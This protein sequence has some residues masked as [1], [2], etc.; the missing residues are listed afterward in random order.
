[1][2]SSRPSAARRCSCARSSAGRRACWSAHCAAD[3]MSP[4]TLYVFHI[5]Y[6][7]GKMQAYLRYKDIPHDTIEPKWGGEL[8][9]LIYPNTGLM[10]VPVVRTPEGQWLADSTPMIDWFEQRHPQGAVIPSDPLQ[11]FFSRLLEDY[12]DEWLWRPALHYRWSYPADAHALSRRF[13][14][15]FLSEQPMPKAMTAAM[16]RE[17]QHRIYVAG[18]GVTPQT[19]AHVE[20]V[21]LNTLDRL[22]AIFERQP[23][24]LGGRPSLADFGF[25]ASMFRHFSLDPTPSQ[26]MQTRAPAVFEWVAR[27]WNSRHHIT[28]GEWVPPGTL[29]PGWEPILHDVGEAYLPYLHANAVAWREGRKTFDFSV[30]GVTYRKL[31][32]VQYRVWCRERLQDHWQAVLAAARGA[33]EQRLRD[34]G[35]LEPLLRDGRIASHLH[36]RDTPPLCAPRPVALGDKLYRYLIGTHWHGPRARAGAGE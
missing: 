30:Q 5:S 35:A 6:F 27:L 15:T 1:M 19:R 10:K 2:S 26:I 21:Y 32:V 25:F 29:P 12:A 28:T 14:E 4:Y 34:A 17:R 22:Q 16:L 23:F 3:V 7:S 31:P 24:L 20:A 36:E 33:V 18:D 8:L 13:A 9:N 11:A